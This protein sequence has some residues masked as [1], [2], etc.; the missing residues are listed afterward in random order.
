MSGKVYLVGAGPGDPELLTLK[1]LRVL[2]AADVVLFD[3]LANEILLKHAPQKAER[4]YVGKKKAEHV[5]SQ[6][7][8]ALLMIR[9]AQAGKTV[10]RLKGGDPFLFGRG[11]EE[12]E[13]LAA[14]GLPFE[15]VPGVTVAAGLSA[16]TGVPLTHREHSSA[17]MFVTGH[18]PAR[19][20]WSRFSG[21]DTIVVF[22]GLTT[23]GEIAARLIA[24]G[25][26]PRTPAMAVRWATRPDQQTLVA[27][28]SE[29]G[30]RV[31]EAGL[32]PP[33]T[34]VIGEV[35]GLRSRLDW[36][37]RLPLFGRRI[38]VTRAADQ[39]GA[40]S[41]LLIEA[42]AE[43][44]ELPL[45]GLERPPDSSALDQAILG[46]N[47]YDWLVFTSAN[48]VRFF[49]ERMD[50]L[51]VDVRRW[52]PRVAAIGPATAQAV[53]RLHLKVDVVPE[54][55]VAEGLAAAFAPFELNGRKML[56][57]RAAE[58]RDLVHE[59][60]RL[61]GAQVDIVATYRNVIPSAAPVR[62]REL[63]AARRPDWVTFTSSSTVKN[64]LSMVD[65][66]AIAGA[67]LASIGPATSA[68]MRQHGLVVHAEA[69]PHTIEG[70]VQAIIRK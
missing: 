57:A 20:D 65:R 16:Y 67:K 10:V 11:A 5:L 37:E 41:R 15:V 8:I 34:I 18:E 53:E 1:G 36:F 38:V 35:V 59:A 26:D 21:S 4:I 28:L 62:A 12:V 32:K 47:R 24:A 42:G 69:A 31:A 50:W 48:G 6:D 54:A 2:E 22:M 3:H 66:A 60:L 68:T 33:A 61:Q 29:L 56:L 23:L 70:L 30:A 63:F 14:A 25:R 17:V 58:G 51:Q 44:I 43:A 19:I 40:L 9:H 46:L 52:P 49:V 45:I 64:L 7:E 27:P 55:F 13:A 39:A